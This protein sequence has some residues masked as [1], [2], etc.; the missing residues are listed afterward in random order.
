M[1]QIQFK[2]DI[3]TGSRYDM[4]DMPCVRIQTP[5]VAPQK[6][7]IT[8]ANFTKRILTKNKTIPNTAAFETTFTPVVSTSSNVDIAPFVQYNPCLKDIRKRCDK[9]RTIAISNARRA[10]QTRQTFN[11]PETNEID[12]EPKNI[13]KSPIV[14]TAKAYQHI[15]T[16]NRN[17]IYII[18]G[19]QR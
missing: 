13:K 10:K 18:C 16:S 15:V 19:I 17:E 12:I 4:V 2:Y 7:K 8:N 1:K 9:K 6:C 3:I 14:L 11:I 5:F